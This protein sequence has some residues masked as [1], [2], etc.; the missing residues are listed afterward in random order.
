MIYNGGRLL[1]HLKQALA[2]M[3][4]FLFLSAGNSGVR[5]KGNVESIRTKGY[6]TIVLD[7]EPVEGDYL[8]MNGEKVIGKIG[9]FE[10]IDNTGDKWRYLARYQLAENSDAALLRAGIEIAIKSSPDIPADRGE[11]SVFKEKPVYKSVIISHV[12]KREMVLVPRGKFLMGSNSGDDDEYPEHMVNLTEYYIDRYEV[13]NEDYRI[14]ADAKAVKYP[15]SWKGKISG[16][17][18]FNDHYFSRLPVIVSYDEAEGYAKW[19]GKRLPDEREWEK[20]ARFPADPEKNTG[21]GEYTWG[22]RFRDGISNTEEFWY[23]EETGKNLKTMIKEKYG[24]T[25]LTKGLIPVDTY[26]SSAVSFYGAVHMDGNATE[27]TSSWYKGYDMTRKKDMRFGTQY[28]VIRGGGYNLGKIESRVT[29]RKIGGIPDLYKD[30]ISG[31]RC[32]KDVTDRDRIKESGSG[33]NL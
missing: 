26:D 3:L 20:A 27:W 8:L 23:S 22:S 15:D 4:A 7:S 6:I 10:F 16:E 5:I 19:C 29:D 12:D 31:F 30:R 11:K 28:K 32:V 9:N 33:S 18:G 24:L 13:T 25:T 14:Y 17:S 2:L 1:K 21:W